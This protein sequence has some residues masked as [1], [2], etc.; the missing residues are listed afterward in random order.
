M[1]ALLPVIGV[2]L[3]MPALAGAGLDSASQTYRSTRALDSLAHL[4]DLIPPGTPRSRVEALLGEPDYSP[5]D[6]QVY[7]SSQDNGASA[8]S[9]VIDYRDA[10]GTVTSS[11]QDRQFG[12]IGE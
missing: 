6:G 11:V 4:A 10:N 9:L 7:Y 8:D 5:V 12:P 3:A 1:R 2:L